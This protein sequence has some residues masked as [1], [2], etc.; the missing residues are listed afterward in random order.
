MLKKVILL[1]GILSL[2]LIGM[3]NG[4]YTTVDCSSNSSFGENSCNQCFAGGE[5]KVGDVLSVF[6]DTWNND[7]TNKKIMYK[8]DIKLPILNSL[9]GSKFTKKP[10]DDTFWE[11]TK[12]FEALKDNDFDGYVLP[13]G[14]KVSWIKSSMGAGY[15]VEK[16]GT[17]GKGAGMMIYDIMSYNI[18]PS[19]EVDTNKNSH[20][21]C[22]LFTSGETVI[23]PPVEE[24]IPTKKPE[25]KEMTKVK[26]G[27][28]G[29]L[30]FMVLSFLIGIVFINR[31][32]ILAFV[33]K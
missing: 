2:S 33:R 32:T 15:K 12:E 1:S 30:F 27:P 11:Y 28:E 14:Q 29:I 6:D 5:V 24:K 7:T 16:V 22:V 26:T 31:K 17:K 10:N 4:A 8:E 9:N 23:N 21:E 18:L 20:K 25:I 13:A 19:G 3:A